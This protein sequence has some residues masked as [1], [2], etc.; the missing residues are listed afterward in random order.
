[1]DETRPASEPTDDDLLVRAL[2][3]GTAGE[4]GEAFFRALVRNVARVLG[5]AGAWVTELAPGGDRLRALAFWLDD[6]FVEDYEYAVPGTPCEGVVDEGREM[7]VPDR[8]VELFPDDPDL[9]RLGAVSYASVP[10]TGAD[11]SVLG[12]LAVLDTRSMAGEPRGMAV[13]RIFAHRA[14]AELTRLRTEAELREREAELARLLDSAMDAI[15]ELDDGLRVARA[16]P[17][18]EGFFRVP[19]TRLVGGGSSGSSP[20]RAG[21]GCGRWPRGSRTSTR[22]GGTSGSPAG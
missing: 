19:A 17:S 16:N 13:L 18:A 12:N 22:A 20:P 3:E 14:A 4:T 2:V 15:L 1:M 5:V 21:P 10:L 7:L 8:V 9:A 6:D 11:G